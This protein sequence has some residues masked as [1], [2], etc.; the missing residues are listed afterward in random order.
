VRLVGVPRDDGQMRH[1]ADRRERLAAEAERAD[2]EEVVVRKLGGGVTLDRKRKV[3]ARH[4]GAV[5]AHPNEPPPAAVGHHLDA[6]RTGVERVLDQLLHHARRPLHHLARGDAVD[7]AFGELADGHL[8]VP[9]ESEA[10]ARPVYPRSCRVGK[11]ASHVFRP[12]NITVG[13]PCP[14][15]ILAGARKTRGQSLSPAPTGD[16][17]PA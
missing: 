12:C 17:A 9:G 16:R 11:G 13:A 15:G 8:W 4:A 5:V 10:G 2:V 1:R 14:R 6:G 3:G 7:D